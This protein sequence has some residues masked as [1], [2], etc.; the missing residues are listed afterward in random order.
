VSIPVAKE[1]GVGLPVKNAQRRRIVHFFALEI[2][3]RFSV[4]HIHLHLGLVPLQ[5]LAQAGW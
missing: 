2:A 4:P 5:A 1:S 3:G